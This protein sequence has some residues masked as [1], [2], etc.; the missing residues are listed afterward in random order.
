MGKEGGLGQAF[1][2]R[3]H[4]V[5]GLNWTKTK[6]IK[7]LLLNISFNKKLVRNIALKRL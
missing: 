5:K 2:L 1:A 7:N 3:K 4:L 6:T